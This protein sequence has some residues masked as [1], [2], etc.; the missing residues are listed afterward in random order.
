MPMPY[1]YRHASEEWRAWLSGLRADTM[2]PSDNTLYTATEAVLKSFRARLTPQQA[3]AFADLLPT[4][5]RA[6]FVSGWDIDAPLQ[7]WPDREKLRREMLAWRRHHNVSPPDL[8]DHLLAAIPASM[9][10]LDLDRVLNGI[11][12]QA[13]AFWGM[14]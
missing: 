2:V 6:I 5:L 11:G 10:A 7:D 3:L 13:K 9:R 1:T 4:V 12:P 8:L 14:D